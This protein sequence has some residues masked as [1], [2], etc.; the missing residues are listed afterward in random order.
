MAVAIAALLVVAVTSLAGPAVA[1]GPVIYDAYEDGIPGNVSSL[2]FEATSTS[3]FGDH[4]AFAGTERH[5]ESASVVMSSWGCESGS[6]NGGDCQ[7]TPGATFDHEITLTFYEVVDNAGT[8]AAGAVI[9]GAT[10]TF[11]IPY[12]P[13]VDTVNCTGGRW[14]SVAEST[15]FNGLAT[16]ITFEFAGQLLPDEVIWGISY[17][18][19]HYGAEPIG[20]SAACFAESGGCG[21]DSLN[22]GAASISSVVGTDIEEES[23]FLDSTWAGAYCDGGTAGT[24]TFRYDG[25]ADCWTDYR[26]LIKVQATSP[27]LKLKMSAGRS[28]PP[29][30]EILGNSTVAQ[31]QWTN[32]AAHTGKFSVLLEKDAPTTE[33]VFA[34]ATVQGAEG[35]SVSQLGDL[36][37]A[38]KGACGAGAPRFNLVYDNNGDGEGDGLAFYG[39]G[40]HVAGTDGD[41]TLMSADASVPDSCYDFDPLFG[42]CE[43][44]DDSTVVQLAVI[45]DEAGTYYIDDIAVAGLVLGEPSSK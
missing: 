10:H 44:T 40:N 34:G 2:G 42:A 31:A 3:E 30:E 6:W 9:A 11:A 37:L 39:C 8:P 25:T 35:L 22:V 12:R 7:T 33:F 21:Y 16:E 14:Y 19:T 28:N 5:L 29:Y 17:N 27:D 1:D 43:L 23:A 13:S 26:P 38:V 32:K 15:C 36:K 4:I 18:T 24:G 41:W 20:Q 45:V